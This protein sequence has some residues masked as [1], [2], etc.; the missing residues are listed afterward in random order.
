M[1]SQRNFAWAAFPV[2]EASSS[3]EASNIST[4]FVNFRINRAWFFRLTPGRCKRK[5]W[6]AGLILLDSFPPDASSF[7][8]TACASETLG[9]SLPCLIISKISAVAYGVWH[10]RMRSRGK[11]IVSRIS[12]DTKF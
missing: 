3:S 12:F 7:S 6:G 11:C 2:A 4:K 1:L 8:V 5:S 9:S 10:Q